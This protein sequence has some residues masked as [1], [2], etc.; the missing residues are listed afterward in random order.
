VQ[1]AH[2]KSIAIARG[3]HRLTERDGA[4]PVV[5]R[6]GAGEDGGERSRREKVHQEKGIKNRRTSKGPLKRETLVRP[7]KRRKARAL[8]IR[9]ATRRLKLKPRTEEAK[10]GPENKEGT[11]G[12]KFAWEGKDKGGER[13]ALA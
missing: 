6:G 10:W 7:R 3:Q 5:G 12:S 8:L 9:Y 1:F 2:R 13:K 4:N 11:W